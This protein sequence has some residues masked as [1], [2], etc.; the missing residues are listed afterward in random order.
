MLREAGLP[1]DGSGAVLDPF[2]GSGTILL[3]ALDAGLASTAYG[4]D[5]NANA[6]KGTLANAEA[7]GFEGRVHCSRADVAAALFTVPKGT[8]VDAVVSNPPWGVQT[9]K[10]SDLKAMYRA[11]LKTA[12]QLLRPGGRLV[13]LVLRGFLFLVGDARRARPAVARRRA[14]ARARRQ[15]L[16]AEPDGAPRRPPQDVARAFA[17]AS[18]TFRLVRST[19]IKTRNNLPT[20]LVLEKDERGDPELRALRD[21]LRG[22]QVYVDMSP[23]SHSELFTGVGWQVRRRTSALLSAC[24]LISSS[25]AR[26]RV[27]LS[28]ASPREPAGAAGRR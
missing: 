6:C 12:W 22:L 19:A 28:R 27:S 5:A 17:S 20:V 7:A 11:L 9:G 26:G 4:A 8:L 25:L 14:C 16:R 10:G 3:E 1:A 13:V 2:C 24:A 15:R 23:S 18:G 21:Q